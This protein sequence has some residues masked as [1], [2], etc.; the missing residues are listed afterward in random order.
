MLRGQIRQSLSGY[1]DVDMEG[2]T[3]RT[4]ARGNFRKKGEAP[5]VGDWVEFKAENQN[6][7]YILRIEKRKN[8]LIRPPVANIDYAIVVTACKEPKFSSNLLDRQLVMLEKNQITPLLFFS[9]ADLLTEEEFLEIKQVVADYQKIYDCQLGSLDSVVALTEKFQQKTV[10][11]MGQT[12]AGK[13]TLLNNLQPKLKLETGEVSKALSRGKHT[14]RKVTLLPIK[15]NLIADT[16]GFS[17]FDLLEIKKEELAKYFP[18]FQ[19]YAAGCKFRSCI[20]LN[21]PGCKVKEAVK[22]GEI[23]SSRYEN[24]QQFQEEISKQKVKYRK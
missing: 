11:V 13:S 21:E 19:N 10:V 2:I 4:R 12:G 3:Y 14:T 7:G 18:D 17:S 15:G 24:Y 23:K 9:K 22:N 20:H 6:E 1:Y 5:L 8:E 16:P